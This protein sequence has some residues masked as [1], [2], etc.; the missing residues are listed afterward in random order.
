MSDRDRAV[1]DVPV[2]STITEVVS[3]IHEVDARVK[4]LNLSVMIDGISLPRSEWDTYR[5]T[6]NEG[7]IEVAAVL[8]G[9]GGKQIMAL[10]AIIILAVVAPYIAA[11]LAGPG[12]L[13]AG[14]VS[15]GVAQAGIMMVGSLIINKIFAPPKVQN[16]A[17]D[18]GDRSNAYTFGSQANAVRP[19]GSI[20]RVYGRHR[21]R[22]DLAAVPYTLNVGDDTYFHAIYCFGYGPLK[23]EDFKIGTNSLSN[24]KDYEI[25]VHEEFTDSAQLELYK[26][27]I[28]QDG[29]NSEIT[30]GNLPEIPASPAFAT[31]RPN[32][33]EAIVDIVFLQGLGR[34]N[35]EGGTD[36]LQTR[37]Q[38]DIQL[39]GSGSWSPAKLEVVS[40]GSGAFTV[41]GYIRAVSELIPGYAGDIE[42]WYLRE[43]TLTA[44]IGSWGTNPS[45]GEE[46]PVPAVGVELKIG[47]Y[48]MVIAAATVDSVTFTEPLPGDISGSS[49]VGFSYKWAGSAAGAPVSD[50]GLWEVESARQGSFI[51][52]ILI[53][54]PSVGT[55]VIRITKLDDDKDP[56][57]DSRYLWRRSLSAVKSLKNI[58]PLNP[59]VPLTIVE[60]RIKATGQL[61]GSVEEF[62]AIATS[63][64]WTPGGV[65]ETRN[66]AWVYYDLLTGSANRRP[67]ALGRIDMAGLTAWAAA[68]DAITAPFTQPMGRCDIVIDKTYTLWEL[69]Q[70][71]ASTGRA[72]PSMKDNKYS[73]LMDDSTRTPVQLFTPRNSANLR[74]SRMYVQE[75]HGLRVKWVDP[76]SSWQQAEVIIY[77]TGRD[78]NNSTI[79]EELPTFGITRLES[80][81]RFGRY[82]MAQGKLRQEH[83]SIETDIEN[84]VCVRGDMV[85]VAHDVI[86]VGGEATR[87]L[88][89]AGQVLTLDMPPTLYGDRDPGDLGVRIRKN[90][91][92]L[93]GVL[94]ISA[95]DLDMGT[96][97]LAA[98]VP[99][100]VGIGDLLVMG[101][102][103]SVT[104]QYIVDSVIPNNELGATINLEEFAPGVY[105]A[106]ITGLFP[107][108]VP[109]NGGSYALPPPTDLTLSVAEFEQN[110]TRPWCNVIIGWNSPT[111]SSQTGQIFYRLWAVAPDGTETYLGETGNQTYVDGPIDLWGQGGQPR[112]Y[113]VR[114]AYP[115]GGLSLPAN[116]FIVL[117]IRSLYPPLDVEY[118][119]V[120]DNP[121]GMRRYEFG[122][123]SQ[124]NTDW[125]VGYDIRYVVGNVPAPVW[126]DMIKVLPPY[127]TLSGTELSA[128]P[129]VGPFT[130]AARAIDQ[131]GTTSA[132]S[133]IV[134]VTL[135]LSALEQAIEGGVAAGPTVDTTP[136]PT[137]TGFAVTAGLSYIIVEQ[138]N[139][140]YTMGRGHQKSRLYGVQWETGD[141]LPVFGAAS[142]LAEFTG[143]VFAYPSPLGTKWRMWL[144]WVTKDNI[145]SVV[146]AGGTNGLLAGTGLIGEHDLTDQIITAGKLADGALLLSKFSSTIRPIEILDA[147]PETDNFEGRV[148]YLTT[149]DKVYRHSGSPAGAAGFSKSVDGSDILAN[150]IVANAIQAG[151]ITAVKL[152]VNAIAVGT[153]AIEAGAI[154]NAMIGTAAIDSAKIANA[155]V[156]NAKIA[157]A[158]INSAKIEDLAVNNAKIAD[159]AVDNAKIANAAITNAKIDNLAVSTLKIGADA[160]TVPITSTRRAVVAGTGIPANFVGGV[161]AANSH[162]IAR[163]YIT[164]EYS[165]IVYAHMVGVQYF[166][167]GLR[168]WW[169]QMFIGDA[170]GPCVG[171]GVVE[172]A[173]VVAL[174]AGLPAGTHEVTVLWWGQ[175]NG[176]RIGQTELFI[177][178]AKR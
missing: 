168:T 60:L 34:V 58:P 10:I 8:N 3:A 148:V 87:I 38:V 155:A 57:D 124:Q 118:F 29:Y 140:T 80:A 35:D 154:V 165:G 66:P 93:T 95:F 157:N 42:V 162:V 127:M 53:K 77:N 147:L 121:N 100:G 105:E 136:P 65:V 43:G 160:V 28:W 56:E 141:P 37:M 9:K 103:T 39:Q 21:V 50:T 96:V 125:L 112:M 145:E 177:M 15:V 94:T 91:S 142:V 13:L 68:C 163:G 171:G 74:S 44:E 122:Y 126:G 173:P 88:A 123:P 109:Q 156:V 128:P 149:D 152:A 135:S 116:G 110:V 166:G 92:T 45:T 107:D 25:V 46:R 85:L 32:I 131:Y 176:V 51:S 89:I 70:S 16:T 114:A 59:E 78:E 26:K 174:S 143:D 2:G 30:K 41:Q 158:A 144:K 130:F 52:S 12:G 115:D 175:D 111:G 113:L 134:H 106:E 83:F 132:N 90:N 48:K 72:A 82:M 36:P 19:F 18:N 24:Y 164:L 31:T 133:N 137:P 81:V 138:D 86:E 167:E 129:G 79:F 49:S 55:W 22:P 4:D 102:L 67:V 139:P 23:L 47:Q 178:G 5:I 27:D 61:N 40:N 99:A 120:I 117:P 14:T 172:A 1:K 151:A 170:S 69:L 108:Y 6:G 97:T 20:M 159:L 63:K 71:V 7:R 161:G 73:V 150:T 64:L 169:M 101:N 11:A 153:A 119:D 104:G 33:D 54:F 62:S 75:P 98:P 76:E 84:I 17:S 146:P